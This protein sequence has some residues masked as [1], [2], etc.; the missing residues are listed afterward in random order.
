[1]VRRAPDLSLFL[2]AA[3]ARLTRGCEELI[4]S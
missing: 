1:M 4:V 2:R 3:F